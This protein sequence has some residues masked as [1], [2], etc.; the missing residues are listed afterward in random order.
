MRNFLYLLTL[1]I[2]QDLQP[3]SPALSCIDPGRAW[4]PVGDESAQNCFLL[5]L[6]YLFFFSQCTVCSLFADGYVSGECGTPGL[7][8][9]IP[10]QKSV[11]FSL[12]RVIRMGLGEMDTCA[13]LGASCYRMILGHMEGRVAAPSTTV[14]MIRI[15]S[16]AYM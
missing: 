13:F 7:C 14:D 1:L 11:P 6:D 3:A 9:K 12:E 5:Y 4:H 2:S 10:R 8:V 16:G 15:S